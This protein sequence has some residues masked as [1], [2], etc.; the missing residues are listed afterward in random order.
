MKRAT[1]IDTPTD[2]LDTTGKRYRADKASE[3]VRQIIKQGEKA[4]TYNDYCNME[5]KSR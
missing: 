3:I 1:R 5:R 4:P 2:T